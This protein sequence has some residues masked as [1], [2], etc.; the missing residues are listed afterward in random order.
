[1]KFFYVTFIYMPFKMSYNEIKGGDHLSIDFRLKNLRL[2]NKMT[3]DQLAQKLNIGR[4]TISGYE[5]G[6]IKPSHEI[7]IELCKIFDCTTDYLLGETDAKNYDFSKFEDPTKADDVKL[8]ENT[9]SDIDHVMKIINETVMTQKL[10]FNNEYLSHE[11]LELIKIN[12]NA[13]SKNIKMILSS[14]SSR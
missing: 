3:Q 7:L 11:Q 14:A 8:I 5:K 12:I 9:I 10:K 2:E 6:S 13:C 4:T 1:M